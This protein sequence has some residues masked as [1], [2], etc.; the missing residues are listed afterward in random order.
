MTATATFTF[1]DLAHIYRDAEGRVVPSVTQAMKASGLINFD[2]VSPAVLEHKR[3][4]G[5]LVHKAA[6]LWDRGESLDDYEIPADVRE[7]VEGH[8]NFR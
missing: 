7:Y 8:I 6:E 4:L 3:Q 1:D 2:H 5:T